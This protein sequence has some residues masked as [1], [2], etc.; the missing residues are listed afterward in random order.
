[1]QERPQGAGIGL[2]RGTG[3]IAIAK[4]HIVP[5]QDL[6]GD[7]LQGLVLAGVV[8]KPFKALLVI[9]DRL[10]GVSPHLLNDQKFRQR[11]L[12]RHGLI[13]PLAFCAVLG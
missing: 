4:V 1:M 7:V 3:Q 2:Y 9:S 10:R 13:S 6:H 5:A 11:V 12:Y 8:G